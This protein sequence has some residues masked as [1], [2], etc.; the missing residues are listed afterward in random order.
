VWGGE[1]L[2]ITRG[3]TVADISMATCENY[4][5]ARMVVETV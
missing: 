2:D 5:K 3:E 1:G 4:E